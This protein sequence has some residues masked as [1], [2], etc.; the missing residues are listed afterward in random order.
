VNAIKPKYSYMRVIRNSHTL[1]QERNEIREEFKVRITAG[2]IA[3]VH[4]KF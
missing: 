2:Y 4:S 1:R 3:A